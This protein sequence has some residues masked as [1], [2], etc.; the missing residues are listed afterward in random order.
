MIPACSTLLRVAVFGRVLGRD[1]E[2]L[3]INSQKPL[4]PPLAPLAIC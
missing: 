4:S 1:T 2:D 3:A